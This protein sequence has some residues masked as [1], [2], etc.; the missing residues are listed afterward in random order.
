MTGIGNFMVARFKPFFV[1]TFFLLSLLLTLLF[2]NHLIH[3]RHV[4]SLD[5]LIVFVAEAVTEAELVL[6]QMNDAGYEH[7]DQEL[8]TKARKSLFKSSYIKGVAFYKHDEIVC[9]TTTG[10]L[11]NPFTLPDDHYENNTGYHFWPRQKIV[12]STKSEINY[13]AILRQ[14]RFNVII[15]FEGLYQRFF[16]EDNGW[17]LF[18][19]GRNNEYLHV[20]GNLSDIYL[21]ENFNFSSSMICVKSQ[22]DLC[23]KLV[24]HKGEG[25][26]LYSKAVLFS[27]FMSTLFSI[28]FIYFYNK[29]SETRS[30]VSFRVKKGLKGDGFRWVYQP[31][32]NIDDGS[33]FGVEVLSR[34]EDD[35][36][37][38]SPERFIP[39]IKALKKDLEF[40]KAMMISVIPELEKIL[41]VSGG[42]SVSFNI[43]PR[44]LKYESVQ[45]LV[46]LDCVINS[47]L[48][49]I[50]EVT[51][52]EYLDEVEVQ[53]NLKFF[54]EKGFGLAIDDFGT[55]Y[56][57]L[58]QLAKVD[59]CYIK[60]DRSFVQDIEYSSIK[61]SLIPH[62]V[63]M[64]KELNISI[65]A[66]GVEN[67][68]Q[69]HILRNLGVNYAQGWF[70][71]KPMSATELQIKLRR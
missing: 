6:K 43:Y 50:L 14:G 49:I 66:E 23:F 58:G 32:V 13:A 19:V 59:C 68:N 34:F 63:N 9:T 2:Y 3:K 37:V 71:G 38:I 12:L 17:G 1:I 51:E 56:S 52:D 33:I 61:S 41:T 16:G 28:V 24:G 5:D 35:L 11:D 48:N 64:S 67:E 26:S 4:A 46:E 15:N 29:Y 22:S 62:I 47:K 53:K 20:A 45:T 65:L 39:E 69:W 18:L 27:I 44:S 55:G 70:F 57:N 8:M 7:C 21:T 31:L 10:I 30:S 54:K 36:G 25:Y 42:F 60:I 40:T